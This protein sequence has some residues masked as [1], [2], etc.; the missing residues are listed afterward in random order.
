MHITF[1]FAESF[2]MS[3]GKSCLILLTT[4]VL[5]WPN[6]AE[7]WVHTMRVMEEWTPNS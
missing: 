3:A 5:M 4:L 7:R 2:G 6:K 1:F